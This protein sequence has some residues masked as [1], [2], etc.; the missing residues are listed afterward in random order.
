MKYVAVS[1]KL[2]LFVTAEDQPETVSISPENE[3][4]LP[5]YFLINPRRR[6]GTTLTRKSGMW[7]K[8]LRRRSQK[9]N[10]KWERMK[11]LIAKWLTPVRVCH[12]YSV[13][14]FGVVT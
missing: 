8:V 14:R 13:V 7:M 10:L 1:K 4:W 5:S 9:H 2:R 11:R 12:P 3:I 6:R